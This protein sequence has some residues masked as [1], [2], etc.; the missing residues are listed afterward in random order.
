MILLVLGSS[1]LRKVSLTE[2]LFLIHFLY[3]IDGTTLD[4]V[5]NRC[6][7]SLEQSTNRSIRESSVMK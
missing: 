5:I 4:F 7:R 1:S 3:L 2:Y 6:M